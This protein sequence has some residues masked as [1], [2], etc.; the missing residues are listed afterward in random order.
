MGA[1]QGKAGPP[2]DTAETPP[3]PSIP[4]HS[5]DPDALQLICDNLGLRQ[6]VRFLSCSKALWALEP[7]ALRL[8][9]IDIE[10]SDARLARSWARFLAGRTSRLGRLSMQVKWAAALLAVT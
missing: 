4:L 8:D 6:A 7:Q 5:L 9:S 1:G 3:P 10:L 2:G